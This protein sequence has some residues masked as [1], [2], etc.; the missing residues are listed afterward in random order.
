MLVPVLK[1]K[2]FKV[3]E[4]NILK[5][6]LSLDISIFRGIIVSDTLRNGSA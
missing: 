3:F 1:L 6:I 5:G 2:K 4:I